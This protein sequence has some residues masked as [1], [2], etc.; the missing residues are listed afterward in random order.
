MIKYVNV[1]GKQELKLEIDAKNICLQDEQQA[2]YYSSITFFFYNTM[3]CV[4]YFL[5][6]TLFAIFKEIQFN[7]RTRQNIKLHYRKYCLVCCICLNPGKKTGQPGVNTYSV[8][9]KRNNIIIINI[10]NY[11]NKPGYFGSAHPKPQLTRPI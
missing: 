3:D 7:K 5:Y 10:Y 2:Q 4:W 1:I 9:E 8:H 11:W 6:V